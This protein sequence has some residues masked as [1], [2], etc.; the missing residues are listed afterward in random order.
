[1]ALPGRALGPGLVRLPQIT[2]ISLKGLTQHNTHSGSR[3]PRQR[4]IR[5]DPHPWLPFSPGRRTWLSRNPYS[6]L[7]VMDPGFAP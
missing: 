6:R 3:W 2:R 4:K 5:E 7:M 1:M